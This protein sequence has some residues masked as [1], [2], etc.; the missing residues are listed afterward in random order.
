MK[1][2]FNFRQR[3]PFLKWA[4]LLS[5]LWG[6]LM[7]STLLA[8]DTTVSGRV[9]SLEDNSGLVYLGV[10]VPAGQLRPYLDQLREHLGESAFQRFRANQQQR[11]HHKF[12]ITLVNPFELKELAP[13]IAKPGAQLEFRLLGLGRAAN[14]VSQ[15]FFVV[16]ESAAAQTLRRQLGL[17][18]KDFHVTLGFDPSDVFG[19]SKGKDALIQP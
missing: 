10:D 6:S 2:I 14:D 1:L 4:A 16:A 9:V 18:P 15:T 3:L 7:S 5:L 13:G 19:I 8:A 12:H 17:K 11:D